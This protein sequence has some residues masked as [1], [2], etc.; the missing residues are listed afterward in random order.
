MWLLCS[1]KCKLRPQTSFTTFCNCLVYCQSTTQQKNYKN[2]SACKFT[3]EVVFWKL[4]DENHSCFLLM[5]GKQCGNNICKQGNFVW[6]FLL[7]STICVGSFLGP[8]FMGHAVQQM[9]LWFNML[10]V[11]VARVFII[12]SSS[13]PHNIVNIYEISIWNY[14]NSTPIQSF[15][16]L[17]VILYL[18]TFI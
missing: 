15:A 10:Q 1:Y 13:V 14:L 12:D 8:L 16:T 6:S 3:F 4:I 5:I 2:G 7:Y 17:E 11:E 9:T 18:T